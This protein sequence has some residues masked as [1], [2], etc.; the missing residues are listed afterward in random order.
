MPTFLNNDFQDLQLEQTAHEKFGNTV[1]DFSRQSSKLTPSGLDQNSVGIQNVTGT[2]S[3]GAQRNGKESVWQS[4]QYAGDL[5]ALAPK[6]RFLFKVHFHFNPPYVGDRDQSIFS[7]LIKSISRPK[8]SFEY[9][10][11]N[12]YNYRTKV[13]TNIK[14]EPVTID[15]YDDIGNNVQEFFNTYRRAYSPIA[16][17][18]VET[19][20]VMFEETGMDFDSPNPYTT[21]GGEYSASMGSLEGNAVNILHYIELEQYFAHGTQKNIFKFINPRVELFDFDESTHE[22]QELHSLKVTFNYDA[23]IID[24][25]SAKT[26]TKGA[27]GKHDIMGE[28]TPWSHNN[29]A[30]K[31]PIAKASANANNSDPGNVANSY[32]SQLTQSTGWVTSQNDPSSNYRQSEDRASPD[33]DSQDSQLESA[34]SKTLFGASKDV[35]QGSAGLDRFER[36]NPNFN[37]TGNPN[38]NDKG[39]KNFNDVGSSNFNDVGSKTFND[40]GNATFNDVGSK[41]FNDKGNSSFNDAGNPAFR[42]F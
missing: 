14:H 12:M 8:I 34:K 38:F 16:R 27:F 5:V 24:T 41:T 37:D 25:D 15:F 36:G 17:T 35:G 6:H 42:D 20:S 32:D 30:Q 11:I 19:T 18:K 28:T 23:L 22:G 39:N 3:G 29:N 13:L 40:K 33:R 9:T 1:E 7:Y 31:S 10:D 26:P 4:V 21:L 2:P